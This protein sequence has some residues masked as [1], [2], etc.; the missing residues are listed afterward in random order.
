MYLNKCKDREAKAQIHGVQSQ[1]Q[2]FRYYFGL[3]LAILLSRH[4][5]SLSTSLQAKDLCAA[6]AQKSSKKTVETLK[7]M[8]CDV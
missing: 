1:R 8:R 7:K 4:N 2:T 6:D 5:D 3:R